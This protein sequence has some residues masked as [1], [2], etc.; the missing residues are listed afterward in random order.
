M[1][2]VSSTIS[3]KASSISISGPP[4]SGEW[5]PLI[6]PVNRLGGLDQLA[7]LF[8]VDLAR[9]AELR[10][11]VF[12]FVELLDGGFVG[13]RQHHLSRPSSVWPIFQ[14][15]ARGDALASAS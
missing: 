8:L 11:H 6:D 7:R 3:R 15:F 14:N 4:V 10:Q 1:N 5:M 12:V 2:G 13:D 9:I